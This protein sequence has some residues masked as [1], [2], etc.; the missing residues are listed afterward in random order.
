MKALYQLLPMQGLDFC[1]GREGDG[2]VVSLCDHMRTVIMEVR[3]VART[4]I[5]FGHSGGYREDGPFFE[6]LRGFDEWPCAVIRSLIDR[7][8]SD[9]LLPAEDVGPLEGS[10]VLL[11]AHFASM[12]HYGVLYAPLP[13]SRKLFV[14]LRPVMYQDGKVAPS[15]QY[16]AE[17]RLR[18]AQEG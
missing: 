5:Y 1:P 4:W 17:Q 8:A 12:P 14:A 10:A 11:L 18:R 16:I 6:D 9:E 3:G 15:E 7:H 2:R 13:G